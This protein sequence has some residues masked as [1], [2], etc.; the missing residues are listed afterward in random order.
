MH[1]MSDSDSNIDLFSSIDLHQKSFHYDSGKSEKDGSR[2]HLSFSLD[3]S[4]SDYES[5]EI[6]HPRSFDIDES[7]IIDNKTFQVD[8]STPLDNNSIDGIE[9]KEEVS[10]AHLS[11]SLDRCIEIQPKP[12]DVDGSEFSVS[13]LLD[14]KRAVL[15][16][17]SALIRNLEPERCKHFLAF[18]CGC[19]Q[20]EEAVNIIGRKISHREWSE[21]MK[22]RLH[23]GPGI[24][25]DKSSSIEKHYRQRCKNLTIREFIEWMNA[26]DLLQNLSFGQK[27]VS[28]CN[29]AH[30][31]IEA[32]KRTDSMKNIIK[33]YYRAFLRGREDED[34]NEDLDDISIENVQ[35]TMQ[36]CFDS[37]V[38]DESSEEDSYGLDDEENSLYS[39]DETNKNDGEK[40]N[41]AYTALLAFYIT[42]NWDF[43]SLQRRMY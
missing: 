32:V 43:R 15:K 24:Q 7:G 29:G 41:S 17:I 9:R 10:E 6:Q 39:E 23:P 19:M 20:K 13:T 40:N 8:I 34:E 36:S 37:D 11:F 26:A 30:V 1:Q 5:I 33:K 3:R 16:E 25:V 28:Y 35:T 22:H 14:G 18:Y 21:A 12:F 4:T 31:P 27:I 38:G 42:N 2:G